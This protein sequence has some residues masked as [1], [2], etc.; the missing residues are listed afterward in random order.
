ML[1][2]NRYVQA[3]KAQLEHV[4]SPPKIP[5]W[6]RI[7]SKITDYAEAAVRGTLSLD[8]ALAALDHDVDQLLEKRRWMLERQASTGAG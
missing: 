4:R 7:A 5:E 1:T 8:D 2:G 6:E 3:F